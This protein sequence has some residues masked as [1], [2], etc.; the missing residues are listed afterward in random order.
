MFRVYAEED[1]GRSLPGAKAAK[2]QSMETRFEVLGTFAPGEGYRDWTFGTAGMPDVRSREGVNGEDRCSAGQDGS[3]C[4]EADGSGGGL[5]EEV[6]NAKEVAPGDFG[7]VRL[8]VRQAGRGCEEAGCSKDEAGEEIG[9]RS[10][11]SFREN[12][13]VSSGS[14]RGLP[15]V[16]TLDRPDSAGNDDVHVHKPGLVA[17]FPAVSSRLVRQNGTCEEQPSAKG[18]EETH[19]LQN[20]TNPTTLGRELVRDWFVLL[21]CHP[22][23]GRTH[24]IRLHC[25][26]VGLPLVGDA[27]YGGLLE[28]DGREQAAHCL[29]AESL[30]LKHPFLGT[31]LS[32]R[33]PDP[34]WASVAT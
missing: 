29:H 30:A 27:R 23:T 19:E 7:E 15:N 32:I 5:S 9:E 14:P 18:S 6:G 31:H 33:A 20:S 13:R 17:A 21:R 26:F 12:G 22:L 34:S 10:D 8:D 1:V 24:Q 3:R 4:C 25:L 11:S 16:T 2:V 28:L